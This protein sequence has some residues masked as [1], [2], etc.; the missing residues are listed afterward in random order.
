MTTDWEIHREKGCEER[1]KGMSLG[2]SGQ[3]DAIIFETGVSGRKG[4]SS[5]QVDTCWLFR[6]LY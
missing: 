6:D 2:E 1:K 5:N 3:V 4:C